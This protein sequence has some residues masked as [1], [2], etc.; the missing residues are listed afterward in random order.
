MKRPAYITRFEILSLQL[1]SEF[2]KDALG[3]CKRI[4]PCI[5]SR[6]EGIPLDNRSNFVFNQ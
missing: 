6:F 2:A 1:E 3:I 5:I 4:C